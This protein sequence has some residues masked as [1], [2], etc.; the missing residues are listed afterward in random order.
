MDLAVAHAVMVIDMQRALVEGPE[1]IP[2]IG[3]VLPAAQRQIEAARTTGAL[4]VFLQNDGGAS[5]PDQPETAGWELSFEPQ[6]ALCASGTTTDSP[7]PT[8]TRCFVIITSRRSAS[9]V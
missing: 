1:A 6:P 2:R 7:E 8:W 5:K 9:A 4:V 3:T